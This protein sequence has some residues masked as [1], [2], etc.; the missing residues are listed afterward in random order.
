MTLAGVTCCTVGPDCPVCLLVEVMQRGPR[1]HLVLKDKEV[2]FALL[3]S[4]SIIVVE[5]RCGL[6][7]LCLCCQ[8]SCICRSLTR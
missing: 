1:V 3:D 2:G 4:V 5:L 6:F 7:G 8:A